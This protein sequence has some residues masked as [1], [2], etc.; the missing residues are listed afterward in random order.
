MKDPDT[1]GSTGSVGIK[2][3]AALWAAMSHRYLSSRF[4]SIPSAGRFVSLLGDVELDEGAIREA[5]ADPA[6]AHLGE[7]LWIV[8]LNRQSLDRVVPDVQIHRLIGMFEA[9]GWQVI[10]LKW[11][12]GIA[13]LFTRPGGAELRR[14]L[15]D[16]P[17]EEYQQLCCVSSPPSGRIGL[18]GRTAPASCDSSWVRCRRRSLPARFVTSADT[19]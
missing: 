10:T 5:V 18:S 8:D 11:G 1:V 16:R 2:A 4:A 13:E 7:L 12:S 9:A 15:E 3:T 19:T 17:N 14:R 6:V